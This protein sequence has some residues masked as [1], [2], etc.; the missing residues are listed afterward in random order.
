VPC[1]ARASPTMMSTVPLLPASH[2]LSSCACTHQYIPHIACIPTYPV[3]SSTPWMGGQEADG[4]IQLWVRRWGRTGR[5]L[6]H[7]TPRPCVGPFHSDPW[8]PTCSA[9][10]VLPTTDC[11]TCTSPSAPRTSLLAKFFS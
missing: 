8:P 9:V 3:C 10:V 11:F 4:G 7:P 1:P 5:R 2:V 6:C